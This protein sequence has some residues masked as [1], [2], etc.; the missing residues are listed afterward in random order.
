MNTQ[1]DTRFFG[2]PRGLST[3]FFVELWERWGY[4]GMRALL[5]LFLTAPLSSGGR[6]YSDTTAYS[7][8]GL[9]TGLTYLMS[10]PGGWLA[11]HF[12]GARRSVFFGGVLLIVGY[13]TMAVPSEP[14]FYT[15]MAIVI[16]GTGLLKPNAST[17]VGQLYEPGD[18]RRDS[19]FSIF[20]MGINLGAGLSPLVCGYVGQRINWNLGFAMAGVG[21]V[22]GLI[23]FSLSKK[24]LGNAGAVPAPPTDPKQASGL[25]KQ[26]WGS[27]AALVALVGGILL[28]NA[29]GVYHVTAERLAD[30]VGALLLIV[31]VIIFAWMLFGGNWNKQERGRLAAVLV[32]FLAAA[33]F[34]SAFEQAGSS[35]NIFADRKSDNTVFG[36]EFP[37]SWY[38]AMNSAFIITLAPVFA[39]IWMKLGNRQ[40]SSPAKFAWGLLFVGLGFVVLMVGAIQSDT[41]GRVSPMYLVVTYCLHTIGELCL[42]PVGLSAM[43]KLAPPSVASLVMGIWFVATSMGNFFGGR[44]AAAYGNLPMQDLFRAVA[45]FSISAA[46]ILAIFSRKVAKLMGGAE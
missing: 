31:V 20:Y 21:M 38:Q 13:L 40:P 34:W 18:K 44:M 30:V 29:T 46:V 5:V 4:Y 39:W 8:Y 43:T 26:L 37:S 17:M 3:L 41:V 24:L 32:F 27:I 19:G 2:H 14:I 7:V 42:S 28:L 12:L 15:G 22:F 45:I 36:Y 25:R 11:D 9:F 16:M 33:L 10:L 35:L 1:A 23:Q 6:A